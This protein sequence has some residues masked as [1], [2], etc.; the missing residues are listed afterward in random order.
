MPSTNTAEVARRRFDD[1][2][3]ATT[4]AGRL[5]RAGV[6]PV[7]VAHAAVDTG[8]R[9]ETAAAACRPGIEVVGSG[10]REAAV[11]RF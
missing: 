1:A 8:A 11:R 4:C 7:I 10:S 6:A 5:D 9:H 3:F 2:G